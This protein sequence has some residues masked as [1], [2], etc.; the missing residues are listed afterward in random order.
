MTTTPVKYYKVNA[1][2]K[3]IKGLDSTRRDLTINALYH[4]I[5]HGNVSYLQGFTKADVA[6][7]DTTLRQF[8]PVVWQKEGEFYQFDAKKLAKVVEALAVDKEAMKTFEVFAEHI[9]SYWNMNNQRNKQEELTAQEIHDS[10]AKAFSKALATAFSKGM[11]VRE[12][13]TAVIMFKKEH[14]IQ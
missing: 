1:I 7:F 6:S 13:E 14:A 3:A 2:G 5:I 12:I 8:I 10:A 9:L 11:T 4:G